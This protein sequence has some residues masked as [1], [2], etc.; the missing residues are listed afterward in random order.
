MVSLLNTL[1]RLWL[2]SLLTAGCALLT[3]SDR[4]SMSTAADVTH[5]PI[6]TAAPHAN[7]KLRK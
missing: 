3:A 7:L 6:Q 2:C 5:M 1:N 4:S